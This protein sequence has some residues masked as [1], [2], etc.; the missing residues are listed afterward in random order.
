MKLI[1]V[2]LFF[3]CNLLMSEISF[4]S[5]SPSFDLEKN[6]AYQQGQFGA[7]YAQCGSEKDQAVIGGSISIWRDETFAGYKGTSDEHQG[8]IKMFDQA[9]RDVRLD[10]NACQDWLAQASATWRSIAH[11][12]TYGMPQAAHHS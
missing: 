7:L 6:I 4:A 12:V 10:K 8:L 9:V 2:T 3:F 5:P 1:I 11:L